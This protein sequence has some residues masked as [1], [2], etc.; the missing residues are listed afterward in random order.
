MS[1]K[2]KYDDI[3]TFLD[4]AHEFLSVK[5]LTVNLG[6]FTHDDIKNSLVQCCFHDD[7][8]PSL[9]LGQAQF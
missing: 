2:Q 6:I 7:D 9:Q 5:E 8:T 4:D 3:G 1:M